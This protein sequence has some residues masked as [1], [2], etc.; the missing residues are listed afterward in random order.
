MALGI[1]PITGVWTGPAFPFR[2][3]VAGVLGPR[4]D[5]DVIAT[6]IQVMLKTR[7][8]SW[9]P[10]PTFGSHL[11]D[12]LFEPLDVVTTQLVQYYTVKDITEQIPY[13]EVRGVTVT[14]FPDEY[15]VEVKIAYVRQSDATN[16]L[17]QTAVVFDRRKAA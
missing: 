7:V 9:R 13:V 15:L 1:S 2:K 16:S 14:E 5:D 6:A 3:G 10:D 12:L 4:S 8:G 17:R 11:W